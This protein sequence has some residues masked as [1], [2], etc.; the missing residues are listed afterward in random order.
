MRYK[1]RFVAFQYQKRWLVVSLHC[2]KRAP[3][4]S[5]APSA[6]LHHAHARNQLTAPCLHHMH[7]PQPA[8]HQRQRRHPVS[9]TCTAHSQLNTSAGARRPVSTTCAASSQHQH[10]RPALAPCPHHAHSQLQ[11]QRR[12]PVSKTRTGSSLLFEVRTP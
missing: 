9:T 11:H 3:A 8:Q 7:S 5:A 1:R 4:P 2:Q 10:R 6:R 12:Q